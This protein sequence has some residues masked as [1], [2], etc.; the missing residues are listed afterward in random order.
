MKLAIKTCTLD[1][2][3]TEMLDFCVRQGVSAVEIGTG[4]WSAAPHIDLDGI[5]RSQTAREKW[6]YEIESRGLEV[7]ALN[8]A[9]NPL[10][11][12][13]DMAVTEKTFQLAELLGVRKIVMMSGL[14]AGRPR[15]SWTT[16]GTRW[17]SP[18]GGSWCA[19]RQTAAWSVSPWRTTGCSLSTTRRRFSGCGR[20][21]GPWWA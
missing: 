2:P 7:C 20:R 17:P 15:P 4:N 21:W 10:A 1:M 6:L 14:P 5:L 12:A 19:R 9:G 18:P 13:Q 16:S 11:Y 8:C 3:F